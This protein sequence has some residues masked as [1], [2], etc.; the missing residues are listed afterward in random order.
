MNGYEM[1][2]KV[3]RNQSFIKTWYFYRLIKTDPI[4]WKKL[5]KRKEDSHLHTCSRE[6]LRPHQVM[7]FFKSA[8]SR[9]WLWKQDSRHC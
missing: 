2:K 8:A 1:D 7:G 6:N 5:S 3:M 4:T 9:I